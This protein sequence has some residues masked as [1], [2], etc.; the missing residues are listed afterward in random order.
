[1]R[2]TTLAAGAIATIA[3]CAAPLSPAFAGSHH[4]G[5]HGYHGHGGG[6]WLPGLI[7]GTAAAIVTAP[8]V[9]ADA[10]S[11][12]YYASPPPR[13]YNA[14]PPGYY[15]APPQ[16]YYQPPPAYDGQPYSYG[17]PQQQQYYA[18]QQQQYY[19]PQQQQQQRYYAPQQQQYYAP[20]QQPYGY[21]PSAPPDDRYYGR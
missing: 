4:R 10:L 8:L 20:Q 11:G 7:V 12:P 14:P 13:Y 21:A 15:G 1:M 16:G 3:L 17:P 18:P 9:L 6:W 19:A 2:I 5:G